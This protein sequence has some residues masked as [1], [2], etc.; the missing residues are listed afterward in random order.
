MNT[1]ARRGTLREDVSPHHGKR[2]AKCPVCGRRAERLIRGAASISRARVLR[3]RLQTTGWNVGKGR[4]YGGESREDREGRRPEA[5]P[6]ERLQLRQVKAPE[7][8]RAALAQAASR[9]GAPDVDVAIDDS[10]KTPWEEPPARLN[11]E[12][13]EEPTAEELDAIAADIRPRAA[14][15]DRGAGFNTP[16]SPRAGVRRPPGHPRGRSGTAGATPAEKK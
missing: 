5:V 8:I 11:P 15:R 3:D 16:T 10:E 14:D 7:T 6:K 12:V 13:A 9:L 4:Q 1:N 2:H